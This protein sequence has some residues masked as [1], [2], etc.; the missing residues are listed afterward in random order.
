MLHHSVYVIELRPEV[1]QRRKF[2]EANPN[3]SPNKPCVYVG[4]T[5]IDPT[6]RF[7]QHL[8]GYK[9]SRLVRSFGVRLRL[10]LYRRYNPMSYDEAVRRERALAIK[11]R[12]RGYAVWQK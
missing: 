7:Q 9:S 11:L 12:E 1:L 5:G 10:R 4:L 3:R 2:A 6:E 8:A